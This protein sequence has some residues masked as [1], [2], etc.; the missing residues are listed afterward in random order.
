[1]EATTHILGGAA[2]GMLCTIVLGTTGVQAAALATVSVIGGLFPD[3]DL[4]SSKAGSKAKPLSATINHLFGHRT[5]FHSPILYVSL[6]LLW[7]HFFPDT[8]EWAIAF[9]M[10]VASHILLDMLN[11]R[12][13]PLFS[14]ARKTYHLAS[15]KT[16]SVEEVIFRVAFGFVLFAG[17]AFY[18]SHG[19]FVTNM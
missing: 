6:Y 8:R 16:G 14:P 13:I 15:I 3:V 18:L 7:T 4:C 11:K 1:M 17:L 10:G 2:A 19:S 12:G 9:I 5:L